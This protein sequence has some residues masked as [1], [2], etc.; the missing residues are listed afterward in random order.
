MTDGNHRATVEL[1]SPQGMKIPLSRKIL[2]GLW[3]H[4]HLRH[5]GGQ[6]TSLLV[7]QVNYVLTL[8]LPTVFLLEM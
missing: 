8:S 1:T 7:F 4:H 3:L 6:S 2:D 5:S